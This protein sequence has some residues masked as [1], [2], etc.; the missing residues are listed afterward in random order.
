MRY[1]VELSASWSAYTGYLILA[2]IP[3]LIA[4]PSSARVDALIE[5]RW[6]MIPIF[7]TTIVLLCT[8]Y[9][10]NFGLAHA[11]RRGTSPAE[12]RAGLLAHVSFLLII[13]L[14]YWTVFESISGY[15]LGRLGGVLGY[16]ALYGACW[17][18]IGLAIGRRWT[19]EIT[20]FNIKYAVL[21]VSIVGT[22]F[23]LRPLNPFLM[24]SLWFGE[25]TLGEQW[26]FVLMGYLVLALVLG[27]FLRWVPVKAPEENAAL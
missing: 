14:P 6:S 27:V 24:L 4:L 13:S 20:R 9:S 2:G 19:S 17:A 3:L 15:S 26:G 23:V 8:I 16:I 10:L 7:T 12:I 21:I 25:G 5:P 11:A 22:F 1:I 18:F